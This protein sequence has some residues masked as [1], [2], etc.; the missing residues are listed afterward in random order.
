M[1][2]CNDKV[3]VICLWSHA[4]APLLY[5]VLS[6]ECF[7]LLSFLLL[8]RGKLT[9]LSLA[10]WNISHSWIFFCCIF[11]GELNVTSQHPSVHERLGKYHL[12]YSRCP[13]GNLPSPYREYGMLVCIAVICIAA[14][15]VASCLLRKLSNS[16]KLRS[17]GVL[18]IFFLWHKESLVHCST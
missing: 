2:F 17:N 13:L 14:L 7:I 8:A 18:S 6:Q 16:G 10:L 5:T 3:N 1:S 9:L 15:W 11:F 12:N 4:L